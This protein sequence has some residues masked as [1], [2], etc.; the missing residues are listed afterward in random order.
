MR[1]KKSLKKR[2]LIIIAHYLPGYK[3]GGPVRSI[4]NLTDRLGTEYDFYVLTEDRDRGDTEAYSGINH[5]DWNQIGNAKVWYVRPGGFTKATIY[6]KALGMDIVYLCGCFNDYARVALR[7]KKQK[8]IK[9]RLIIASMGL[10]APGAFHIKY[11][12]K[13][14][15]VELLKATGYF[16]DVEWSATDEH[17]GKDIY[18]RIGKNILCHYAQDIPRKIECVTINEETEEAGLRIIFLSRI[19]LEKN[20]HYALEI[21]KELK[22]NIC[23][24]IYGAKVNEAYFEECGNK[25]KELPSNI[26]CRYCGEIRPEDVIDTFSQYQVFFFPTKGENYGHVI[27]E[28]MA[29]GCIPVISDRTPW[30]EIDTRK[31]GWTIP[32]EEREK[33]KEVLQ[34]LVNMG[35]AR[36]REKRMLVADYIENYSK[37]IDCQGYRDMFDKCIF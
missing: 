13:K 28:A 9:A 8:R 26:I 37:N 24:D 15:Y 20:L 34:E 6:E 3:D 33:Y 4:Q 35:A 16:K 30:S 5:E 32:L 27:F 7:L 25:I 11:M 18:K 17:E 31:I 12:K 29:G 23:F 2:I 10:F 22:G 1:R 14:V 19:S 21:L 36:L